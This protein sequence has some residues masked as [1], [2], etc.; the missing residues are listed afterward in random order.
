[1]PSTEH[2]CAPCAPEACHSSKIAVRARQSSELRG[3]LE[4]IRHIQS[5]AVVAPFSR[6]RARPRATPRSPRIVA[7]HRSR[8]RVPPSRVAA[9]SPAASPHW[10]SR[11]RDARAAHRRARRASTAR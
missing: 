2:I 6:A 7:I 1:M 11:R 5:R 3:D 8:A 4:S 9:T 10:F